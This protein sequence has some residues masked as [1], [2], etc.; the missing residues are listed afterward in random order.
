[1]LEK[2]LNSLYAAA[3]ILGVLLILAVVIT[4][5]IYRRNKTRKLTDRD[6]LP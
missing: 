5:Q 6:D 2:I 4:V 1:L 3:A